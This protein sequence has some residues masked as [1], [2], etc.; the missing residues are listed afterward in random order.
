MN[1]IFLTK[2]GQRIVNSNA[3]SKQMINYINDCGIQ[4]TDKTV[5]AFTKVEELKDKFSDYVSPTEQQIAL[6]KSEFESLIKE[7]KKLDDNVISIESELNEQVINCITALTNNIGRVP[8]KIIYNSSTEIENSDLNFA[9]DTLNYLIISSTIE[10][11]FE[12][13]NAK[14]IIDYLN[15][16][17]LASLEIENE[18][19]E[20]EK[21]KIKF[22]SYNS[23]T[24]ED[25]PKIERV[26]D[27]ILE[28]I[29]SRHGSTYDEDLISIKLKTIQKLK[30]PKSEFPTSLVISSLILA[31]LT[32]LIIWKR[33]IVIT[34][35]NDKFYSIPIKETEKKQGDTIKET[36]QSSK[37]AKPTDKPQIDIDKVELDIEF[38][39]VRKGTIDLSISNINVNVP[40]IDFSKYFEI[41]INHLKNTTVSKVYLH[42]T[43]IIEIDKWIK[44]SFIQMPVKEVGGFLLGKF[45][46]NSEK[47]I[48]SVE[49]FVPAINV[50]HNSRYE[51]DFGNSLSLDL[52]PA[53]TNNPELK[54]VGWFHTHPYHSVFL[55]GDDVNICS[56]FNEKYQIAMVV[57]PLLDELGIFTWKK[58]NNEEEPKQVNSKSD[59]KPKIPKWS[60]A[61]NW[62]QKF[63]IDNTI[64]NLQKP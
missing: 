38:G 26:F 8:Y 50:S 34:W 24:E 1:K 64:N 36:N 61:M 60:N 22:I 27:K 55:S 31:S 59:D 3:T 43:V 15:N 5:N 17:Q 42:Y 56:F 35:L 30:Q 10:R 11:K 54:T 47:L 48:V 45:Y 20:I 7:L 4:R 39:E 25:I 28:S 58:R 37:T 53:Q 23:I 6:I 44:D 2:E 57:D 62:L 52:Y 41:Q 63:C 51:L 9:I 46:Q 49:K 14:S 19:M 32:T 33:K 29:Q 40:Q 16:N 13:T 12:F 18:F 21:L